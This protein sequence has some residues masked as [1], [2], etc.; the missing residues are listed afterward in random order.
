MIFEILIL[1]LLAILAYFYKVLR[2]RY[3]YW[4]TLGIACEE[5]TFL[6]GNITGIGSKR[7][8][9]EVWQQF[10][11]KYKN[12]GPFAGFYWFF[13]PAVFVFDPAL[14]KLILIKDF[15]KFV[16]RGFYVNEE[17]DPL[18]GMLF[19]LEGNKWRHMRNKL[20][21]TFTS[22][23]MKTMF[24]II[25]N[26]SKE[27]VQVFG[28]AAKENDIIEV[29]D[30][31]ARF[32]TDVIG[33]CAFGL[34]M[35]SLRDPNNKFRMMG[36]KSIVEQRYGRV[37]IAFRNSFPQLARKLH[38]KDTLQ[39]VEDFFMGIV[40]ETVRYREENNVRRNDFMDMLIDLKNNKLMKSETGEE[41]TNLT[42]EEIAAQAFVFLVAGFETS[43][44]TMGFA[45]YELA[46]HEDIQQKARE[47]VI[48]V[49]EKHNQEFTYEAMKEMVYMEQII[50]ETLRLYTVLPLITR[51]ASEDYPVPGHPKFIIKKDMLVLIPAGAIHRDERY[52]PN[53]N[54]FNPDNFT[55]DKV[56]QRDSVL[57]MPFGDGP[58]NCIG[59]RFGKMQALVGLAVLLKN[60]KFTV[61]DK[62]QIPM[63][64]DKNNFLC[65]S[66]GGIHLRVTKL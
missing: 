52:Y 39:E 6:L 48:T 20:S 11:D 56:A 35:S 30:L 32:T 40:K 14:L 18:S 23:K 37:G 13:K 46:Q 50:A 26:I 47:E 53:P 58:R 65:S 1:I 9:V 4:Q 42:M 49:L 27:F 21:P 36:R 55:A 44:T 60:F 5:P 25:T 28:N 38:M 54:V 29:G 24:P 3:N 64:Y 7:A 62:T 10:Y 43:S 2:Q 12:T 57:H 61:C 33:S 45:L 19:N 15:S 8:F 16:D 17:D 34:E 51:Y 66:E 63:K 22:G 59:M 41:L 31:M